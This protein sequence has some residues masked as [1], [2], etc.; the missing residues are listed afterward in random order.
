MNGSTE[1][2]LTMRPARVLL[3]WMDTEEALRVQYGNVADAQFSEAAKDRLRTARQHVASRPPGVDQCDLVTPAP[4]QLA[5]YIDELRRHPLT[6]KVLAEGWTPSVVDLR[7]LCAF[8]SRVFTGHA[9]ER[10]AN[11]KAGDLESIAAVSLPMPGTVSAPAC[12]DTAR[13][14]WILSSPDPNLRLVGNFRQD[15]GMQVGFGFALAL[16]S[17]FLAVMHHAG[18]HYLADGYHRAVSFLRRGI[19]HVP[20]MT[21]TLSDGE[22]FPVPS[23]MLSPAAYL[24]DRPPQ[25]AD[26]LKDDVSLAVD[27]PVFRKIILIQAIEVMA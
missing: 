22:P 20:A 11:V 27:L 9:E 25:L 15:M 8:Q 2:T 21:R 4:P 3:G 17:S 14:A 24:G 6:E 18:R 5:P 16:G 7:R 19:T 13:R 10:V 23:G 1:S 12:Y 26:F